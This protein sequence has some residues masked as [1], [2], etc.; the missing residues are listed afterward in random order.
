MFEEKHSNKLIAQHKGVFLTISKLRKMEVLFNNLFKTILIVLCFYVSFVK[1]SQQKNDEIEKEMLT[2]RLDT[3]TNS[4]YYDYMDDGFDDIWTLEETGGNWWLEQSTGINWA[5]VHNTDV[6]QKGRVEA[7]R[8]WVTY[9]GSDITQVIAGKFTMATMAD[10]YVNQGGWV[11]QTMAWNFVNPAGLREYKPLI[12]IR[13]L[14]DKVDY[15][16][17][18][19]L[20]NANTGQY[21]VKSGYPISKLLEDG[22]QL[23]KTHTIKLRIKFNRGQWGFVQAW[24]DGIRIDSADYSGVTYPPALPYNNI[25]IYW[26][27]GCY[28]SY[29]GVHHAKIGIGYVYTDF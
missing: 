13:I 16:V 22:S 15:L 23:G 6:N 14:P 2:E 7:F 17:Y 24:L 25:S 26:K 21:N 28:S 12:V 8:P 29:Y 10:N 5:I 11:M 1:C 9:N 3:P 27:T 18:D 4:D 20:W 19:Y